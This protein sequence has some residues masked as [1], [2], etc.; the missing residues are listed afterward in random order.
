MRVSALGVAELY[1]DF[2]DIFVLD[3]ADAGQAAG[4]EKLGMRAVVTDTI[5]TGIARKKA[6]AR[7]V[8]AALA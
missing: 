8:V 7:A 4:V 3:Q 5:M 1:R 2:A 6:L